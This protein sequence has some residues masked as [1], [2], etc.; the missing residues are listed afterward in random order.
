MSATLDE[1][2]DQAAEDIWDDLGT[3][4]TYQ[5][6][7][8]VPEMACRALVERDVI[9]EMQDPRGLSLTTQIHGVALSVLAADFSETPG[10][11]DRFVVGS[12]T[13]RVESV[14]SND[15]RLV[16]MQV[17]DVTVDLE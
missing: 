13:Y 5:S 4:A 14:Y 3:E 10:P 8:P 2:L 1:I 11:G 9:L 6:K 12:T 7:D 17:K 16:R 15:G